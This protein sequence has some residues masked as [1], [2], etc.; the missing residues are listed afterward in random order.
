MKTIPKVV[1]DITLHHSG[2]LSSTAITKTQN[3][4]RARGEHFLD[5]DFLDVDVQPKQKLKSLESSSKHQEIQ[6]FTDD[7]YRNLSPYCAQIL[8]N[9][10]KE[11]LSP[12]MNSMSILTGLTKK[13][14]NI[15][16][17]SIIIIIII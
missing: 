12:N 4:K 5:D 16:I 15:F 14:C 13:I 17:K 8:K 3:K 2:S 9:R 1:D 7:V 6:T 10:I 11:V